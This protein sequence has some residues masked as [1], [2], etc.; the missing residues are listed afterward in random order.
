MHEPYDLT[1]IV[2]RLRA[3]GTDDALIEV[4]SCET[5]LSTDM[6]ESVSAFANTAGGL[7][8]CG[9]SEKAGFTPLERFDLD[10]VRDQFVTGI[11]DGGQPALVSPITHYQLQRGIVDGRPVLLIDIAELSI[12]DKPCY[13]VARGVQA[14]SY[15]RV[16]DKDIRLSATELYELQSALIPSDADSSIVPEAT[17]DDLD[18]KLVDAVIT[19][20]RHLSARALRG[21]STREAQMERL[22]ITNKEGAVRLAGLLA[23]GIYPQ[24]YFPKLVIDVAVHPGTE[25]S[26]PGAPRFLD[27]QICDGPLPACIEDALAV[28][29]RNLRKIST[30]S[31]AGR[32]EEWEIPKEVLREALANAVIHREY[33]PMFVGESVSVDIY[34]DRVEVRSPGGLWG[35][36]TLDNLDNGDSRC[37]N[38]KLMSLMGATP[39]EY[40]EGF[41][42]ESQ[43]SGILSMIR[44]MESKHLGRP[45][46]IAHA[47]SFC[48]Q[49]ARHGVELQQN[50][51]WLEEHAG[52][53]LD[54]KDET[55]LMVFRERGGELS[56]GQI[57]ST[58]KWDSDDIRTRCE[59]LVA[60][61]LIVATEQDTYRLA[62]DDRVV[63]AD[64]DLP[65][66][67]RILK[68]MA[69]D[70]EISA[71]DIAA[72]LN[73]PIAKIRYR[74]PALIEAGRI[75][76]TADAHSRNRK[77][78]LVEH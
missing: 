9:L 23:V 51:T 3:Q 14:G 56:V 32:T 12:R 52:T 69:P 11:G 38:A 27:R 4:K 22:N 50:R 62:E 19:N 46:F 18:H 1:S 43:G 70:Q 35:G 39:L 31:G 59:Q 44:E 30:V 34:P 76:A 24:Q 48:V 61:G 20:R 47:D 36:K 68:A 10:R 49:F 65:L 7:I 41:V 57:R 64:D 40:D 78:V 72:A 77:Y 75:R 2:E 26:E 74:L 13:I 66:D 73:V 33:S 8:I 63:H 6:W 5:K 53:A 37:R 17:I 67:E 71:R 25:K 54:R 16:D 60:S 58:L 28:I 29:G 42:A 21:A 15:K 55:L 45:A